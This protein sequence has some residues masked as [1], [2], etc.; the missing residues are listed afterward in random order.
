MKRIIYALTIFSPICAMQQDLLKVPDFNTAQ[1]LEAGLLQAYVYHFAQKLDDLHGLD[2]MDI[3]CKSLKTLDSG[4]VLKTLEKLNRKN[5][6]CGIQKKIIFYVARNAQQFAA[7]AGQQTKESTDITLILMP[8]KEI[9]FT[10]WDRSATWHDFGL[11]YDEWKVYE[12]KH[13]WQRAAQIFAQWEKPNT[14]L[15]IKTPFDC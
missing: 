9:K 15:V 4:Y 7:S 14:G 10:F 3:A 1:K 8:K 12:M 13:D 2:A 5:E 6:F 11:T